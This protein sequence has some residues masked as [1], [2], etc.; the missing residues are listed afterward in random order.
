M[1]GLPMPAGDRV[2]HGVRFNAFV[3]GAAGIA[4]RSRDP[5][6]VTWFL[7]GKR[8]R[9][10]E[11][12]DRAA[13]DT[14]AA[15]RRHPLEPTIEMPHRQIPIKYGLARQDAASEPPGRHTVK[16]PSNAFMADTGLARFATVLTLDLL[17]ACAVAGGLVWISERLIGGG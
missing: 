17:L 12:A 4:P 7:L 16:Y 8:A 10:V 1:S 5:E 3:D 9:E 13:L 14:E 15:R 2:R 11:A 6:Y